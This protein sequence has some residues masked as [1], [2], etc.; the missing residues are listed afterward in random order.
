MQ[1][2]CATVIIQSIGLSL[3]FCGKMI[4]LVSQSH[5]PSFKPWDYGTVLQ[6]IGYRTVKEP[7]GLSHSLEL[8]V[9]GLSQET[10][11]RACTVL[12]WRTWTLLLC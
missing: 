7:K 5:I 4:L 1:W 9:G 11:A 10:T 2:D 8:A 3:Q 6:L 12:F